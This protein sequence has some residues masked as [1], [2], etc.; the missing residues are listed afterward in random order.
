MSAE[1]YKRDQEIFRLAVNDLEDKY[2]VLKP[3]ESFKSEVESTLISLSTSV[4]GTLAELEQLKIDL[5]S[6]KQ[7]TTTE[8][9]TWEVSDPNDPLTQLQSLTM[10]VTNEN[11]SWEV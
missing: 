11:D 2:Q 1:D 7:A 10:A 5:E 4:N 8:D 3:N 9:D 6:I